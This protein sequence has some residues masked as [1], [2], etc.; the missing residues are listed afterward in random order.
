MLPLFLKLETGN[1]KRLIPPALQPGDTVGIVAPASGFNRERFL[2]GCERLRQMGYRPFYF[3]SIFERD[4]YFAGSVQRRARELEEMFER[5]EVRA[6]LCA[7]GGYGCRNV[8]TAMFLM[9]LCGI[10]SAQSTIRPKY[11]ERAALQHKDLQVSVLASYPVPLFQALCAV[12][13]EY[14]WSVNWEAAP[15][16]SR[17]DLVDDTGPKWRAAHPGAR[18]VTQPAGGTFVSAFPEPKD[19]SDADSERGALTKL[20]QDYNATDN[21][22]KFL[23]RERPN[24]HFAVVGTK[25][26]DDAGGLQEVVPLLDTRVSVAVQPRTVYDTLESI[27]RELSAATGSK[28]FIATFSS[29]LL[30]NTRVTVGGERVPARE[31]LEQALG[32]TNRPLQYDLLYDA[33]IPAYG[34]N[35]SVASRAGTG[36]RGQRRLVPIDRYQN[37]DPIR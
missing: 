6:V 30:D 22:G 17:F 26:R 7:R 24:G 21:P 15:A 5:D 8:L 16:Y 9:L 36:P 20:I 12:R 18:G 10:A 33:D 25:V 37:R 14:G 34:L 11:M 35:L 4:L 2:A 31:L 23:L 29:S 1:S 27:F 28:V 19:S 32:G 13:E 3:D